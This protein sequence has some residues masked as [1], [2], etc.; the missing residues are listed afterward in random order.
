MDVP[1]HLGEHTYE[2]SGA[3]NYWYILEV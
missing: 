1:Y 2:A 3:V